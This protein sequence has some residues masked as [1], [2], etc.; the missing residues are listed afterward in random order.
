HLQNDPTNQQ[1]LA[2][3]TLLSRFLPFA[4]DPED[5]QFRLIAIRC[6]NECEAWGKAIREYAELGIPNSFSTVSIGQL[7][8]PASGSVAY[9]DEIDDEL[10]K[11]ED[12][13]P[14]LNERIQRRRNNSFGVE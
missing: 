8:R 1:E 12:L 6:A 11:E 4:L 9:S 3:A 2:A 13:D 5:P 14:E 7:D 10:K